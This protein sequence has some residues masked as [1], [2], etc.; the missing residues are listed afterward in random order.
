MRRIAIYGA[1]GHAKS[2]LEVCR[3]EG[4]EV[5]AVIEDNTSQSTF[6]GFDVLSSIPDDFFQRGIEIHFA[7][8]NNVQRKELV[9]RTLKAS[10]YGLLATLIHSSAVVSE[11]SIVRP[12]TLIMPNTYVGPGA[13]LGICSIVNTGSIVEHDSVIGDFASLGPG[14]TLAGNVRVGDVTMIGMGASVLEKLSIGSMVIVGANSLVTRD[15]PENTLGYGVPFK[16]KG[17]LL[18][19]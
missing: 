11:M 2:A 1:G 14:A 5:V 4:R 10:D 6:C 15:I 8:G 9:G 16:S 19:E 17:S 13:E 3:D 18:L 7:I 12:G